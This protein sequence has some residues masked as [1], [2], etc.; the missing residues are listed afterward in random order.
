M[1]IVTRPDEDPT[2]RTGLNCFL[3]LD[4]R[5]QR[6]PRS[7]A[8]P[9]TFMKQLTTAHKPLNDPTGNR[10]RTRSSV[11]LSWDHSVVSLIGGNRSI[12]TLN[13]FS[14]TTTTL[15]RSADA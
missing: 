8:A 15:E 13:Q 1:R 2:P 4:S 10:E 9:L 11:V 14:P 3:I 7:A 12:T 6:A 5:S